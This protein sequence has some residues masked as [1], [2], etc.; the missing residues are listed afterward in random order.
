VIHPQLHA[1]AILN[2]F[3]AHHKRWMSSIF[4]HALKGRTQ[5]YLNLGR[6]LQEM[7]ANGKNNHYI[8]MQYDDL[9][10]A[11]LLVR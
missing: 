1:T 3:S 11:R 2:H 5:F 10:L 6:F 4:T 7:K 8:S 9:K